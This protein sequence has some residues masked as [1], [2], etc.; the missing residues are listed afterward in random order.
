MPRQ[1]FKINRHQRPELNIDQVPPLISAAR[2]NLDDVGCVMNHPLAQQKAGGEFI[3]IPGCAHR[4]A[5][6]PTP[7]PNL[8]RLLNGDFIGLLPCATGFISK[9]VH[10]TG[11]VGGCL[12][13]GIIGDG[14]LSG[15]TLVESIGR[16]KLLNRP[17]DI[18]LDRRAIGGF[19]SHVDHVL[20]NRFE[21]FDR[22]Q[23][24]PLIGEQH[25][26]LHFK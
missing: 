14:A 2:F 9:H 16:A 3:V 6:C 11:E 7:H 25:G 26:F 12:H 10:C 22:Q 13:K 21:S 8:K 17:A 19:Q 4:Y 5:D 24:R 18:H 1:L 20:G 23:D 15:G